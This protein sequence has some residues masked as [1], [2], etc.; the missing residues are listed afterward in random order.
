MNRP[1]ST[2][3]GLA[4]LATL[5]VGLAPGCT[6]A[7]TGPD[8]ATKARAQP[9][10]PPRVNVSTATPRE[11]FSI[12]SSQA[13]HKSD[14][15]DSDAMAFLLKVMP[16]VSAYD[17]SAQWHA[18][19]KQLMDVGEKAYDAKAVDKAFAF[20][21]GKAVTAVRV[22]QHTGKDGKP[23][24]YIDVTFDHS[25]LTEKEKNVNTLVPPMLDILI[26]RVD[27]KMKIQAVHPDYC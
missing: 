12:Y 27:G 23:F 8:Q 18:S 22:K 10:Q 17:G 11:N 25:A 6:Q 1:I 14:G 9:A 16:T 15:V 21:K 24:W 20:N 19:F 26:R 7:R 3:L 4:I 13:A 2:V 5:S